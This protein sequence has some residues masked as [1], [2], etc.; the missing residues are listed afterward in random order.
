MSR[1]I[2]YVAKGKHQT[3]PVKDKKKINEI[4]Y[5][6]LAKRDREKQ[7]GNSVSYTHLDVYKRQT[8]TSFPSSNRLCLDT[9]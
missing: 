4:L 8:F 5:Y 6:L 7:R 1:R 3:R 2:K 9:K